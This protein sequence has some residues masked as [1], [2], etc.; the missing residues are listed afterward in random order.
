V[1]N[2]KQH[3]V[4]KQITIKADRSKVWEALTNP[5]ITKRYF[6]NCEVLSDWKA[7]SPITFKGRM[8][9]VMKI[10]MTGTIVDIERGKLLKYTLKNKKGGVS[11]VT[12]QLTYAKGETTVSV[13]DDVGKADGVEKRYKRSVKGWD[14]ILKGLKE[15]VESEK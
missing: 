10:E 5:E 4:K 2:S 1:S 15:V 9:L 6:F 13:T 8:F 3:V 11:T 12:D 7:G 14:K